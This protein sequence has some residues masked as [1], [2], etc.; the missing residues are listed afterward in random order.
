M[1]LWSSFISLGFGREYFLFWKEDLCLGYVQ[2]QTQVFLTQRRLGSRFF[3]NCSP[4]QGTRASGL[5]CGHYQIAGMETSPSRKKK[6]NNLWPGCPEF[7]EGQ[8]ELLWPLWILLERRI[9]QKAVWQ[10]GSDCLS[11]CRKHRW[12]GQME[13]EGICWEILS[14]EKEECPHWALVLWTGLSKNHWTCL[15]EV[16][17]W[18]LPGT[19]DHLEDCANL[20]VFGQILVDLREAK[21]D[22]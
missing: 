16:L 15:V 19:S 4:N 5:S 3:K 18:L 7:L 10:T 1:S 2:G 20:T 17:T 6:Q 9:G 8:E 14:P 11:L 12:E 21:G 22:G 13:C